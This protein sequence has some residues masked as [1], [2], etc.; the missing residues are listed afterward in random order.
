[1]AWLA[2]GW[3]RLQVRAVCML[4][5]VERQHIGTMRIGTKKCYWRSGRSAHFG[6][7]GTSFSFVS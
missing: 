3:W 6:N 2:M 7:I 1:M 4:R 5:D